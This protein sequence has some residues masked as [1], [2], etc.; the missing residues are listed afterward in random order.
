MKRIKASELMRSFD[1]TLQVGR[2]ALPYLRQG[3]NE[4]T[5][6]KI[7]E[8]I[9]KIAQVDAVA[10]TDTEKILGFTGVGCYYHSPGRPI[11]T[12]ATKAVLATG[13][14][15][16][17]YD[18]R[19]FRCPVE[20]CPCPLKAAVIA[21]LKYR[22]RVVG[23][24]KLYLTHGCEVPQHL[25]RLA[26]GITDLLSM[27]IELAEVDRQMQLVTKAR[28]EALQAQIRPHFLFN[29]LNTIVMFSRTDVEKCRE[30]LL[31][32]AS[33]FRRSLNYRGDFI[34]VQDEI[35]YINTYLYLEQARFGGKIQ[36]RFKV[37]PLVLRY[38][39]PILTVQPLV[40]NAIVH[41]LA[42]KEDGGRLGISARMVANEIHFTIKDDGV[43]I[44]PERME[45]IFRD[46][47]GSGM[48]LGLSNVNERIVSL[49]GEKYK[50]RIKSVP[51]KGTTVL[52]RV[53]VSPAQLAT[54]ERDQVVE[55]S[56]AHL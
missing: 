46:G 35:D 44:P 12:N 22:Q 38:R 10:I 21:P 8:I 1:A 53:P 6:E 51:G 33:F 39:I 29:V 42:P 7:A 40:E 32:L 9:H 28:L 18:T 19:D 36:I 27:Q 43:G 47:C 48:G 15:A 56:A 50:L 45:E 34:T 31:H 14:F 23:T 37:A 26:T 41:G 3:L 55:R 25:V 30:L 52:V 49:Y 11:L 54:G 17:V 13:E 16:V 20:E 5:A 4:T 2:E 24:V